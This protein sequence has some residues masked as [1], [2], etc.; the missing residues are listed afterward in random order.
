MRS[1]IMNK[2]TLALTA[3]AALLGGCASTATPSDPS[4]DSEAYLLQVIHDKAVLAVNAQREL[5]AVAYADKELLAKRQNQIDTERIDVNYLGKPGPLLQS[6]ALRYGYE[7]VQTG[8]PVELNPVNVNV[9]GFQ[10]L[11]ILRDV[12]YQVD[13]QADVVLDKNNKAIRLV[14]KRG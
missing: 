3:L 9:R 1:E 2:A 4:K 8:K 6:L 5:A 13:A 14:F 12:G 7:F 10:V 11:E